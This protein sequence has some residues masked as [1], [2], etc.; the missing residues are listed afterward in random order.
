MSLLRL[1]AALA[2][3]FWIGGL[4][5]VGGIAAPALFE[6]L[7]LHTPATG[8][9]LAGVAFGAIFVRFQYAAWAACG[10]LFLSLGLRRALGPR[11]RWFG[12]R[13]WIG[14]AMLAVSVVT[15]EYIA[16]RI[17]RIRASVTGPVASLPDQDPRRVA[18]EGWHQLSTSLMLATLF[19]GAGLLW[20]EIRDT[21]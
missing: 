4:M 14:A 20:M 19:S 3:A 15:V 17:D 18:L 6:A 12:V 10:V 11:P 7:E 2:L 21:H 1:L 16:P 8:R 13:M 9:E 5:A